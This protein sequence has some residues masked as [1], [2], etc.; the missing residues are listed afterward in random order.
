MLIIRCCKC[1]AWICAKDDFKDGVRESHTY[2]DFCLREE[3]KES[4]LFTNK[5][6]CKENG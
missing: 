2:C 1:R 6:G 3:I 5:K 4:I